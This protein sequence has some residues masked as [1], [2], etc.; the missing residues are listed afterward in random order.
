MKV[1]SLIGNEKKNMLQLLKSTV[2][3]NLL[4]VM[5]GKGIHT[6]FAVVPQ[7]A[8]DSA[9]VCDK[10]SVKMDKVLSMYNKIF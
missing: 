6:S 10:C 5:K 9:T 1:L 3:T 4:S 8:E 2:R 7:T